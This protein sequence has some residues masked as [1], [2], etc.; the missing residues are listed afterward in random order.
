MRLIRITAF[1]LF[2]AVSLGATAQTYPARPVNMI[3]NFPPG[4]ATD[5]AGRAL[6]AA[7]GQTLNQSIVIENRAGAGGT[8]GVGAISAAPRDGY[9]IGFIAI[10]ALTTLP[11]IRKVSYQLDSVDYICQ[12]FDLPVFMLT[13]QGSRFK[14]V[15]ELVSYAKENPGKVNY[16]TVGPGTL[17][18]MAAM[19]FARK[20]DVELTHIPFQGEAPAV[21][22]LL[23]GHVDLYFGTN[24]VATTHNLRRL[25]IATDKRV[26]EALDTPTLSELGYPVSWSIKGGV[27]LPVGVDARARQALEQVCKTAVAGPQYR[28]A[29]QQMKMNVAYASG[30]DF[31][32]AV[33]AE[34]GRNRV[35][36]REAGL[37]AP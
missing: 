8:I 18:H 20:A 14:S 12:A 24:A 7:M 2:A 17:P 16:A 22:N 3:V 36:L 6:S 34:S 1:A 10:A 25:S 33:L 13:T 26:P 28:S 21:T 4:G 29:M 11:Q 37:L 30:E 23:G 9:H 32:S 5:L 27:I 35:L 15:R 31:K 19:D